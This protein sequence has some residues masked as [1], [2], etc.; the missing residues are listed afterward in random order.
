MFPIGILTDFYTLP[1]VAKLG[2]DFLEIPLADLTRLSDAEFQEFADYAAASQLPLRSAARMLP[3][4]VPVCGPGVSA[5]AL[6]AYLKRAFGRAQK[7]GIRLVTLDA[8]RSRRVPDDA[9]TP[10]AWRQLGNFLRL[11]QGH[12]K[13]CGLTVALEPVRKGEGDL[14]HLVSEATLIAGLLQLDAIAV[15]AHT[16]HMG[17]AS[18]PVS[19]LRRAGRLLR[20]VHVENALSRRMPREGDGEDYGRLIRQL[21]LMNYAG[22]LCVCGSTTSAMDVAA[23]AALTCLRQAAS[24]NA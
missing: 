24:E 9:N 4:D 3:D 1:E 23:R 13:E 2:F 12:A 22:G 14:L 7:L 8:P 6:H 20:H 5:T 11:C 18:E 17:M 16:G 15:S 21:K 19:N 10:F